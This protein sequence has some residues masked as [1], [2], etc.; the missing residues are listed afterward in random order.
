MKARVA[1]SLSQSWMRGPA[2]LAFSRPMSVREMK[3]SSIFMSMPSMEKEFLLAMVVDFKTPDIE[4]FKD[5][6]VRL[7]MHYVEIFGLG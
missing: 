4:G 7:L 1:V 2:T 6:S 3:L 5:W